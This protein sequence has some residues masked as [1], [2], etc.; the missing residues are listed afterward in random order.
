MS[1]PLSHIRVLDL[2][3]VRS[4]P[5]CVRQLADWGA[6]CIKVEPPRRPTPERG[7]HTDEVLVEFGFSPGEIADLRQEKA[8]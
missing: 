7:E 3:R 2:T 4:G 6:D 5:T 8:L 1:L